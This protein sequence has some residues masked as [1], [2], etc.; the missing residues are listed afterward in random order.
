MCEQKALV[1]KASSSDTKFMVKIN[2]YTAKGSFLRLTSTSTTSW[3]KIKLSVIKYWYF[4]CSAGDSNHCNA[5][6][7]LYATR[8]ARIL[9]VQIFNGQIKW[10]LPPWKVPCMMLGIMNKAQELPL[11]FSLHTY[12]NAEFRLFFF[13][14]FIQAVGQLQLQLQ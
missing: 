12:G 4:W 11:H 6:T 10:F 8:V 1:C 9:T 14:G 5:M 3:M 13:T 2:H 7:H